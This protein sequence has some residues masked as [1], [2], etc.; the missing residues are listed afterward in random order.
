[1]MRYWFVM[2]G[3]MSR[4]VELDLWRQIEPY[5]SN[6]TVLFDRILVYGS[7]DDSVVRIVGDLLAGTGLPVERR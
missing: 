3:T 6:M 5:N 7:G 2:F 1:M 4:E